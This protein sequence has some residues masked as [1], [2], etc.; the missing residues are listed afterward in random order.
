M[1]KEERKLEGLKLR[2]TFEFGNKHREV[3]KPKKLRI[4]GGMVNKH[5]WTAYVKTLG[6]EFSARNFVKKSNIRTS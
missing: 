4:A 5:E 3:E 1:L 6:K 2:V